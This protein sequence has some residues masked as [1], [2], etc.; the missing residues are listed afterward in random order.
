M[1]DFQTLNC[2]YTFRNQF[3][4]QN[5]IWNFKVIKEAY[6]KTS[7]VTLKFRIYKGTFGLFSL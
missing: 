5:L 6:S 3:P 4:F 2:Y 7:T 1:A